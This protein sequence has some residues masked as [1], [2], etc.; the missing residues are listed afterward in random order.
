MREAM[1]ESR[2][3]LFCFTL[4]QGQETLFSN[5]QKNHKS[6][7]KEDTDSVMLVGMQISWGKKILTLTSSV[8]N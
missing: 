1:S 7:A 2:K 5:E 3:P 8:P 6:P 4:L